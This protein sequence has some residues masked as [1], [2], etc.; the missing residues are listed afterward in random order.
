MVYWG[1]RGFVSRIFTSYKRSH[2]SENTCITVMAVNQTTIF[3]L[4]YKTIS[5]ILHFIQEQEHFFKSKTTS[6]QNRRMR[7]NTLCSHPQQTGTG[8]SGTS[9]SHHT[10]EISSWNPFSGEG[11]ARADGQ[12]PH[13][14]EKQFA[15]SI[16]KLL[17]WYHNTLFKELITNLLNIRASLRL[18]EIIV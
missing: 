2:Y 10:Q 13:A 8:T 7:G 1:Q 16:T 6:W 17:L 15:I 5:D 3:F 14:A 9:P 18:L 11:W 4:L 12:N